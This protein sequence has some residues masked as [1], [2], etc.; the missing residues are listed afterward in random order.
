MST[1]CF[2]LAPLSGVPRGLR[3]G[4][5]YKTTSIYDAGTRT[6]IR[7]TQDASS[8]YEYMRFLPLTFGRN[9]KLRTR[10]DPSQREAMRKSTAIFSEAVIG[11]RGCYVLW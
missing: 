3:I 9:G 10:C 11:T 8:E 2:A 5:R 6:S 4:R 7:R 1:F